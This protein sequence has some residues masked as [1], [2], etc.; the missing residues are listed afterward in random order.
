[1]MK[2]RLHWAMLRIWKDIREYRMFILAFAVYDALVQLLFGAFCPAVIV[3]GLPCPGCGMTRA[4]FYFATGQFE[5]GWQMNPLGI[6]WLGLALY[7]AIMRYWLGRPA[8]GVLQIGGILAGCMLALYLYR[9][10]RFFPGAPPLVYEE[11]NL[12]E[13]M[14]ERYRDWVLGFWR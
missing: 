6:L 7:F 13:R 8:K 1:M 10:Y 9:M 14:W 5:K 12:L 2:E 4:V 11:G 3:T